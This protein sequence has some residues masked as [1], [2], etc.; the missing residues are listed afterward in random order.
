[1]K[2]EAAEVAMGMERCSRMLSGA[3][4]NKNCLTGLLPWEASDNQLRIII[5]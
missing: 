3:R 2:G 4:Y 1:M 5:Q